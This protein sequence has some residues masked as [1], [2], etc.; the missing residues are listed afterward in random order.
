MQKGCILTQGCWEGGHLPHKKIADGRELARC[1]G[2]PG[3]PAVASI[4]AGAAL[5]WACPLHPKLQE[6]RESS[7]LCIRNIPTPCCTFPH[8]HS[9]PVCG[10]NESS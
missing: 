8:R 1:M 10:K 4:P 7:F 3:T 2:A 5:L 9:V 6:R